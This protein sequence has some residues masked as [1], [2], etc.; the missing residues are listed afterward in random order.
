MRMCHSIE[1]KYLVAYRLCM[2]QNRTMQTCTHWLRFALDRTIIW[3]KIS[4]FADL[5]MTELWFSRAFNVLYSW[6]QIVIVDTVNKGKCEPRLIQRHGSN[7]NRLFFSTFNILS[8]IIQT[9]QLKKWANQ[10]ILNSA[11]S[12]NFNFEITLYL[13]LILSRA[14]GA[15]VVSVTWK[16]HCCQSTEWNHTRNTT[17]ARTHTHKPIHFCWEDWTISHANNLARSLH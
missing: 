17:D 14:E 5:F 6:W 11:F 1:S 15:T 8:I 7:E 12:F 3:Q 16:V 13:H 9:I 10:S 4:L 2:I